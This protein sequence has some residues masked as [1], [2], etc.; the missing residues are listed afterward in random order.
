MPALIR[1]IADVAVDDPDEQT[2]LVDG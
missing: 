1:G 2:R